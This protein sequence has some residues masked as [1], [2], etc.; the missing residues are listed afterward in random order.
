SLPHLACA[1]L[2]ASVGID[3][4]HV[5]YRGA[6]PA[7]QDLLAGRIDY[8]CASLSPALPQIED[9]KV[10]AIAILSQDRSPSLPNLATAREQAQIN[11]AAS[12][13]YA[14]F[15][16]KAT[17]AAVIRRLHEAAAV[18]LNT[19]AVQLQLKQIGVEPVSVE[20]TSPEYLQGFVKH[21]IAKWVGA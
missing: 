21:E 15:A 14:I 11:L 3:V 18:T 19:P 2:N 20:R 7:M 5:P 9:G 16:P 10:K 6:L 13:W 8:Q 17:P 1:L 4:T 12:T